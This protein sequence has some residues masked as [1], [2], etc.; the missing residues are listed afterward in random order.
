[1]LIVYL[2]SC[3][4]IGVI[5]YIWD[6]DFSFFF[7]SFVFT[8]LCG[9]WLLFIEIKGRK[10]MKKQLEEKK[11]IEQEN[12]SWRKRWKAEEEYKEALKTSF[13]EDYEISSKDRFLL[14]KL[15]VS[16]DISEERATEIEIS[17]RNKYK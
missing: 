1:M 5:G 8:P 16:L 11:R 6:R 3:L 4:I 2:V 15:R 9:L 13:E 7:I 10:E 17:E 12:E 14:N